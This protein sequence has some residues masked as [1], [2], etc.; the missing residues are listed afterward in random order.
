MVEKSKNGSNVY[1]IICYYKDDNNENQD[2]STVHEVIDNIEQG[3]TNINNNNNNEVLRKYSSKRNITESLK[4]KL[5]GCFL[6]NVLLSSPIYGFT[7]IY[8]LHKEKLD[9]SIALIWIPIIF[10]AVYLLVT[11]WLFNTLIPSTTHANSNATRL[12]NRN[13]I[14]VFTLIMSS[15]ISL[16]GFTFSYLDANFFLIFLLYGIIGGTFIFVILFIF[17]TV[18]GI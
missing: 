16:S 8:L 12:T 2:H 4:L 15:A 13:V 3:N 17:L 11:P 1:D 6:M 7:S 10:N 14:I 18:Y 5:F 9:G